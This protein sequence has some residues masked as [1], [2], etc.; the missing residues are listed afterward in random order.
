MICASSNCSR[1]DAVKA[2]A[3]Q[4]KMKLSQHED[5]AAADDRMRAAKQQVA[6]L[7]SQIKRGDAA[8]AELALAAARSSVSQLDYTNLSD[9]S[10]TQGV[11]YGKLDLRA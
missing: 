7:D 5:A 6:A 1:V 11:R 9:Q 2:S 3:N 4:L 10:R 8:T